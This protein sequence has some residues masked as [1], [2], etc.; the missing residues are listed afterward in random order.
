MLLALIMLVVITAV[1]AAAYRYDRQAAADY[2]FNNAKNNVPWSWFFSSHGGDC[3]NFASHSLQA[4]GWRETGKYYY[5]RDSS[6]YCDWCNNPVGYSRTW[7]AAHNFYYFLTCS[8]RAY[9]VAISK[10]MS[11][12][13]GDIVQIDYGRNNNWDHTMVVTGKTNNDLLM[14][15]HSIGDPRKTG[16]RNRPLQKIIN[17]NSGAR[18]LGWHIRDNY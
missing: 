13:K 9:P 16:V 1:P 2:A 3:T 10:K 18:F 15:Y 11:L 6:W 17:D 14:S 4:G 8:G 5:W 7:G 12:E